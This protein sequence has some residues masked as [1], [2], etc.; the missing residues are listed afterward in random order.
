M[1][2]HVVL[3]SAFALAIGAC[4]DEQG[5]GGAPGT[6]GNRV[7]SSTS[8]TTKSSNS[9]ACIEPPLNPSTSGIPCALR[10]TRSPPSDCDEA[11][12]SLYD[13]GALSCDGSRLCPGFSGNPTEKASFLVDCVA[14]CEAEEALLTVIYPD[15]CRA[16]IC[17]VW[18][19]D[20]FATLCDA[21]FGGGSAN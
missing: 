10:E 11:C 19:Y 13:C 20:P 8:S 21:G 18:Q 5:V 17:Q 12:T 15:A 16:T 7:A 2:R 9:A 6:T 1:R 14:W 3:V 4:G